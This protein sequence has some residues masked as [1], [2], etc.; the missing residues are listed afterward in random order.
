[1]LEHAR[2]LVP[3]LAANARGKLEIELLQRI[4]DAH[5]G[6]GA[7]IE[8]AEAYEA[9]AAQAA[10]A[11]LTSARVDALSALVVPFGLIDPDRAMAAIEQAVRLS[12]TLGDPLLH[13]RTELLAAV[14][15]SRSTTGEERT[16]R[17]VRPPARRS[18]A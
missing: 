8:C 5:F 7:M 16:G 18:T 11:G 17:S 15:G 10:G 14:R 9:A 1:M 12:A 2:S 3:H 6:R 4:G 13:A